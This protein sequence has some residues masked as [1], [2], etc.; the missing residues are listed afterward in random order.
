[1]FTRIFLAIFIFLTFS[2]GETFKEILEKAL[3]SSPYLKSIK[4][5]VKSYE[6]QILQAKRNFNPQVQV[7]FGRLIS[8]TDSGFAL[9]N[10]QISQQLRLWGEKY[11][12]IKSAGLRKKAQEYFYEA[13]KRIFEGNLYQIFYEILYIDAQIKIKEKEVALLNQ[14]KKFID[15]KYKFGE[16]LIIDVLRIDRDISIVKSKLET[17]KALKQ[18]KETLFFAFAGINPVKIE[19]N[20]E[21]LNINLAKPTNFPLISYYELLIKS[22][23][24]QIKRQKA[25]AKPQ[26]YIGLVAGEDAVDL[27]KYEFGINISSS[28]PVFYKNEGQIISLV[29]QKSQVLQKKRQV[30]FQYE[31]KLKSLGMQ[32]NA[33]KKQLE[34]VKKTAILKLQN[35]LEIAQKGYQEGTVSFLELSSIRKQYFETLNLKASLIYEIHKTYGE[36]IKIGG[37][38]I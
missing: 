19:G 34:T 16:A 4:Y 18:A 21:E 24:T 2:Y 37:L 28:L 22:Y 30:E 33:L 27:G 11:L 13:Q 9:T 25:L 31:A 5:S 7:E 38:E 20:F 26:V 3:E 32:I 23:N 35:A 10:L 8:Q 17:L 12:A 14:L 1:M 29:N 15:H 6:G 36:Y